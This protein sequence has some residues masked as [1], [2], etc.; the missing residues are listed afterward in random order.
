MVSRTRPSCQREGRVDRVAR[1]LSRIV[2]ESLCLRLPVLQETRRQRRIDVVETRLK[3][4]FRVADLLLEAGDNRARELVFERLLPRL[5]GG[6]IVENVVRAALDDGNGESGRRVRRR[7]LG[8]GR[9]LP[10]VTPAPATKAASHIH[11][12]ACRLG[13]LPTPSR[14]AVWPTRVV[15]MPATRRLPPAVPRHQSPVPFPRARDG[16]LCR[17]LA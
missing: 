8:L 10:D 2:P 14:R 5:I 13:T 6:V 4:G 17:R 16:G 9:F 15:P 11:L 1:L 12:S 3:L 7:L